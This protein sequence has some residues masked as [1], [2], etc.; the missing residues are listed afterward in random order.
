MIKHVYL[1]KIKK[2]IPVEDVMAKLRT[3]QDHIPY[4]V[5]FEIGRDFKGAENSYD[6]CEYCTFKNREDFVKFGADE[7]HA[8]IR[9]YMSEVQEAGVKIDYEI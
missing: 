1:F 8:G 2:E 9:K 7:Y 6:I 4:F 5:D 3:L